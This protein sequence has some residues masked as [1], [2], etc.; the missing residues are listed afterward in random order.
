MIKLQIIGHLGKNAVQQT[1]NGKS[2]LNFTVAH[3]E[4]FKDAKGVQQERTTW[5][6]CAMWAPNSVGPFLLQGTYVFVEGTPFVE[7]YRN[8][9]GAPAVSLKL[10]V[11]SLKLLAGGYKGGGESSEN[12]A[13]TA[14]QPADEL[15]F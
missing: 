15:P 10:R 11:T 9:D 3:N 4:R 12:V 6:D 14:E 5:A 2:V 1:V 13:V 7:L 8:S